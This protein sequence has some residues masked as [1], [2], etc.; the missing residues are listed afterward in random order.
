MATKVEIPEVGESVT[1]V[2]LV[3]WLKADGEYVEKD[4]PLCVLET[5]KADIELPSPSAGALHHLRQAGETVPVGDQVAQI[6]ESVKKSDAARSAPQ[7]G[8]VET[9][10]AQP[11]SAPAAEKPAE[12]SPDGVEELSPAVRKLVVENR[13]D[14]AQITPTGR[15]GRLLKEDVLNFIEKQKNAPP[16]P[17]PAPVN[18]G[19]DT[20]PPAAEPP[21]EK[22]EKTAAPGIE[23]PFDERAIEY[24]EDGTRCVPMTK[25]RKRIAERLVRAQH[26]AAML[27]TFNEIDMTTVLELRRKYKEKFEEVHGIGLGLMSFFARACV[28]AIQTNP[29]VNAY[30]EGDDIVY[31]QY[32][33]LGVAVSTDRGLVVPVI[34]NVENLSLAQVEYEIKRLSKAAREGRLGIDELSGGTFSITNG[35][36]FGS[37]LSTPILNP[38][39]SGILG[40]HT[41]QKRPVVLDD[42]IQIRSMMFVAFTYD[43]RLVDG[44]EA[45][46]FLV[47][48]KEML[49][50]PARLM[51]G[52]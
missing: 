40:M 26:T 44:K 14:P 5:D 49:E 1:E 47:R 31:H 18:R 36:V 52:I 51:L 24:D 33:H 38:P 46:T 41:I 4:E 3:E 15:G 50:D 25:I 37:L 28:L 43:H 16:A 27:T 42:Q 23:K 20:K 39:Q 9:L 2:I 17:K 12:T 13:L 45:V 22:K 29:R 19:A 21:V 35:G 8:K 10:A 7:A 11:K 34:R 6:D 30:L 32:V 48:V